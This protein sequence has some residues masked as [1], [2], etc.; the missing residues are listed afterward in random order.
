VVERASVSRE[1]TSQV[2]RDA[3]KRI[4]DI[5]VAAAGLAASLPC[6]AC[7]SLALL[8]D[9]GLPVLYRQKRVGRFGRVF[10][11][12]KFRTM[13]KDAERHTGPVLAAQDDRRITRVGRLLRKTALDEVPQ[14]INIFKGDMSWVG[15]RPERP[16]FVARFASEIPGYARRHQVRPGLTG[17]AQVHGRYFSDPAHKLR[18]DLYYVEHRSLLLDLR[19]FVNSWLIT[20]KARWDAAAER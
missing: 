4:A 13:I 16:E 1:T 9:D 15:P 14:L 19:L 5:I 8:L 20:F 3:G 18:Y 2:W 6:W 11:I 10:T 12:C 17:A 7:V